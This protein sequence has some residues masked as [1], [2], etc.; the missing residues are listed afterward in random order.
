[1]RNIIAVALLPLLF[2]GCAVGPKYVRPAF[3]PPANFLYRAAGNGEFRR[4]YGVVGSCL[5]IPFFRVSSARR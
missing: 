1:M 5:R 4:G 2:M 3:Q